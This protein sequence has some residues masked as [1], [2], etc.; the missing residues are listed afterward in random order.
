[1]KKHF[2]AL[3]L[4]VAC[5]PVFAQ[6]EVVEETVIT[7]R[8]GP[9]LTN[10]F[11]DNMFIGVAG[12]VN[13]YVGEH[14]SYGSFGEHLSPALDISVGKWITPCVGLRMQY[15]GIKG[16]GWSEGHTAYATGAPNAEG[17]YRTKFNVMNLHGDVMWNIS[18]AISGYREDRVWDVIPYV[19]FGW[20]RSSSSHAHNNEIAFT[21]GILHNFRVS[22]L[23]D[24]TLEMRQMLVNQRFD[25]M[26]G[27]RKAEGIT[28]LTAG[29]TFKLNRRGFSRSA[30]VMVADYSDYNAKI[31]ALQ[32]QLSDAQDSIQ[33][34]AKAKVASPKQEPQTVKS[35]TAPVM[36]PVMGTF[37]QIGSYAITPQERV[38]LGYV[39]KYIKALPNQKFKIVGYAD[40]ATGSP[41][42]N[43]QLS[44]LRAEAV[45]KVLVN[46]Y[47]VNGSQLEVVAKGGSDQFKDIPL[48]RVAIV[49]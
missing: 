19:G 34:L 36:S 33:R 6:Q 43:Q 38:N 44:Q 11:F 31:A 18:N 41:E 16:R 24:L 28:S 22:N 35:A 32:N 26:T 21:C 30:T 46:E 10:R 25:G 20:A 48:N 5:T 13:M 9:Y 15:A 42:W 2:L 23:I 4:A 45:Y 39:A 17:M 49:E 47:S 14:F 8:R 1:M 27:G 3:L 7:S 29:V 12:G 40:S 37:F